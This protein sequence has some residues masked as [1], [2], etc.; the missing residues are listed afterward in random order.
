MITRQAKAAWNGNLK[1]GKGKIGLFEGEFSGN[2]SFS[3]RFE[4]GSG[5][6]PEE[7]IAA[8][9]AGCFSMAL[10][11]DLDQAG[12]TPKLIETVA[13]V[14]M[15]KDGDGFTIKSIHL[16]TEGMVPEIDEGLF[17]E[18]ANGAKE[19]CPVSKALQG[20]EITL[21]SKLLKG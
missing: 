10:A 7:L 16:E 15:V 11:H 20:P 9:H 3:S 18:H 17:R 6:N 8:A 13:K 1:D 5:T 19:N 12:F 14:R 4:N 2:Y 21:A